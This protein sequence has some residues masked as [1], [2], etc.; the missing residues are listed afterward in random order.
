MRGQQYGIPLHA[1]QVETSLYLMAL[2]NAPAQK[3]CLPETSSGSGIWH[4]PA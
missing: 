3:G 2:W 1:G 4:S